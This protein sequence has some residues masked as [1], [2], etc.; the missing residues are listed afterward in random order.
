[1]GMNKTQKGRPGCISD[2]FKYTT[3]NISNKLSS[4][5]DHNF[6][7]IICPNKLNDIIIVKT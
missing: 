1:M 7:V 2:H 6:N 4:E 3:S 5:M